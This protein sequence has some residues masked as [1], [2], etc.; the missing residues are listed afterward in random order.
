MDCQ[1]GNV[2]P[3]NLL[4]AWFLFQ[5]ILFKCIFIVYLEMGLRLWL[6]EVEKNGS[7]SHRPALQTRVLFR[8]SC[9]PPPCLSSLSKSS[10]QPSRF[11]SWEIFWQIQSPPTQYIHDIVLTYFR[12]YAYLEISILSKSLTLRGA[13]S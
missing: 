1:M 2:G 5:K 11:P 8:K 7:G 13:H 10:F 12:K 6:E 3:L 9:L 4:I